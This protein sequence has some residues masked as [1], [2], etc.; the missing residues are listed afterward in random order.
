MET[1]LIKTFLTAGLIC[2][3]QAFYYQEEPRKETKHERPI[4]K[5][6]NQKYHGQYISP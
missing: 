6:S 3:F 1:F 4:P 5:P 2:T